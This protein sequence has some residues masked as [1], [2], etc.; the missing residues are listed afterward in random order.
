MLNQRFIFIILFIVQLSFSSLVSADNLDDARQALKNNEYKVAVIHLKNHLKETP[1]DAQARFLL[2]DIYLRTGKIE[3]S[4]KELGRAHQYAPDNSDYL[5]RYAD[6]LQTAGQY[7][8]IIELFQQNTALKK[9]DTKRLAYVA[10]A[11]LGLKEL[12]QAKDLF[13]QA[14]QQGDNVMALNGLA[15]I[16]LHEKELTQAGDFLSRALLVS[17]D[18]TNSLKLKAKLYNLNKQPKQ[19]LSLYNQLIQKNSTDLSLYLDRAMTHLILKQNKEA[20][21]DLQIVLDKIKLHPQAN[22]ML[23]QILLQEKNFNEARLAAQNVLKVSPDNAQALFILGTAHLGLKNLSQADKNLTLY[24]SQYPDDL[25]AQSLLANVYLAQGNP[26]QALLIL[27]GVDSD[28]R[29]KSLAL[30]LTLADSYFAVGDYPRGIASLKKARILAPDNK[31]IQNR[32]IAAQLQTG[33]IDNAVDE[34][35][36][37]S[38]SG[39]A[40]DNHNYLLISSYIKQNKLD[41]AQDKVSQLLKQSPD[42]TILSTLDA[43]ITQLK[44]NNK[45]AQEKYDAILKT[46]KDNVPAHMGLARLFISQNNW[47]AARSQFNQVTAIQPDNYKAYLGLAAIAQKQEDAQQTEHY[48]LA[49]MNAVKDNIDTRLAIADLLSRWYNSQK[50]QD[51]ILQ[52]ANDLHQTAPDE[53]K[54]LAFL[55]KAQLLNKQ[56]PQAIE[57]LDKLVQKDRQDIKY[58]ALLAK[59]LGSDPDKTQQALSLIDEAIAIAPENV[60]LY[61]IKAELLL[62]SKQYTQAL[63]LAKSLQAQFKQNI[64]G[65]VL[66][67]DIYRAQSQYKKALPLYQQV[68]DSSA[69]KQVL[70]SLVDTLILL[71]QNNDAIKLLIKFTQQHPEDIQSLFKLASLYHQDKQMNKAR[72]VYEDI[73]NIDPTNVITLNNLAWIVLDTNVNKA[74]SMAQRAHEQRPASPAIKDTYG[75]FLAKAGEP[76]KGLK[77]IQEAAQALPQDNDIQYHLAYALH[78]TGDNN[79]AIII[80]KQITSEQKVFMEQQNTI[81]LLKLLQI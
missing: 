6:S 11:H 34:L 17:P 39:Q 35:E 5:F 21:S 15:S 10:Y 55:A 46:H 12:T 36:V 58:R 74:L 44:G 51:K 48:F 54:V 8:K 26:R 76:E 37:L 7:Q 33:E 71:K 42:N 2:G 69:D 20:S 66:E 81:K 32:L 1:K 9:T 4:L 75:Y 57:T 31:K 18:N 73:L 43:L 72:K 59:L 63:D 77:L 80:L 79:Q 30:Q 67:A 38:A 14:N 23:A 61:I 47:Q 78:K 13:E 41:N 22:L 65:K 50:Q 52:L 64:I 28:A 16:A 62:R 45:Q 60:S 40:Q 3:A 70:N 49:A 68:Y 27:Q 29:D 53:T 19:A 24:L 56:K 25:R